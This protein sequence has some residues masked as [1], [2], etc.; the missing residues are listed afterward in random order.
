MRC[1]PRLVLNVSSPPPL[2]ERR[3]WRGLTVVASSSQDAAM[4][5]MYMNDIMDKELGTE[6]MD[7]FQTVTPALTLDVRALSS[8]SF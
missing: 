6:K 8:W 7:I 2:A 4:S 1:F 5:S 3:H